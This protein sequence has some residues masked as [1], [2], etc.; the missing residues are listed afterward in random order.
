MNKIIIKNGLSAVNGQLLKLDIEMTD[1]VITAMDTNLNHEGAVIINAVGMTV[2]PGIIETHTHGANNIDIN[3]VSEQLLNE[4]SNF[5]ACH[6]VTAFLATT[7]TDTKEKLGECAKLLGNCTK[8]EQTG[9]KLIGIHMEGPFLCEEYK[10]A[11]PSELLQPA[12]LE[13]FLFYQQLANGAIKIMTISPEVEGALDF[14]KAASETGVILSMGH[15]GIEY[16]VAKQAICNGI[17]CSTHTMNAMRHIHQHE[18]GVVGAAL[19]SDIYSEVICDGLHV[20]PGNIRIMLKAKG[21]DKVIAV[22]D[23]ISAAGLPDG[24][25]YKL[26]VNDIIVINGDARLADGSTRAGSTLTSDKALRNLIEFTGEPIEKVIEL[27]SKNQANLIGI[28][29]KKGSLE[30]GKDAD[31]TIWDSKYNLLYTIV[32]GKIIYTKG[33]I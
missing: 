6:G 27:M 32:N 12:S 13:D 23:S 10:G 18:P 5:Y 1:G 26:G 9:A 15:T 17:K 22:T 33:D 3:N 21:W 7:L 28:F 20:H 30:V 25:G 29:D 19:D 2:L 24:K 31:I 11:M 16:A 4:L 8:K 14:I